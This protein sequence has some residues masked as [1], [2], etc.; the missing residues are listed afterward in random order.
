MRRFIALIAFV[1]ALTTPA[2][3]ALDVP[4]SLL[5]GNWTNS[6]RHPSSGAMHVA[7]VAMQPVM[8]FAGNV[9]VDGKGIWENAGSWEIAG[10]RLTWR[11]EKSTIAQIPP[12]S[13]D[14]DDIVSVDASTMV[15]RSHLSG[16]QN[17][18]TRIP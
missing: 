4:A 10:H 6:I 11:Y 3:F 7:T 14:T 9:V 13:V 17:T 16:R 8:K 15:L 18:Y 2:A 12:G 5:V 1:A